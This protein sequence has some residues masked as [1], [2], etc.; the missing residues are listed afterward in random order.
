[1]DDAHHVPWNQIPRFTPGETG[2]RGY[3]RKLEF[4]RDLWPRD[5]LDQLAPRAALL[6]EGAA[7]QRVSRLDP[8]KLKSADGVKYLVEALGGQWGRLDSEDNDWSSL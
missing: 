6:I 1:M 7:F 2:M 4:P 8:G 5:Y 3:T